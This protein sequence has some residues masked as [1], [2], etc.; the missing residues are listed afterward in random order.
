MVELYRDVN[1]FYQIRGDTFARNYVL[2][3]VKMVNENHVRIENL[4]DW[5]LQNRD[6]IKYDFTGKNRKQYEQVLSQFI[7][8]VRAVYGLNIAKS[9]PYKKRTRIYDS[10]NDLRDVS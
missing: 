2:V 8:Y 6:N 10:Y 9:P 1:R 3:F 4:N 5:Y 7:R